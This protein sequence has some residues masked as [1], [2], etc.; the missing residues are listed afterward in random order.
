MCKKKNILFIIT[1]DWYYLSHRRDLALFGKKN[2]FKVSIL[3]K[4]NDL[5]SFQI[6]KEINIIDWKIDRASKNI[7]RELYSLKKLFETLKN[8]QP[9]IVHAV[10]LK[11]IIYTGVISKRD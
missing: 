1:E 9:D 3:T 8:I 6:D 11:P 10:G 4:I 7:F 5:K 2:G